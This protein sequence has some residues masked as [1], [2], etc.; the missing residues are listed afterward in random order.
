MQ[1]KGKGLRFNEGK[2]RLGL[3]PPFAMREI[4]RVFTYGANKYTVKN[5]DGSIKVRGDN[6]WKNG[7]PWSTVIDSMERHINSFKEGA[8][9]DSESGLYHLAHAATNAI[10][11]LEYYRIYPEGDDRWKP[12]H[13]KVGLDIDDVICEFIEP[14][15]EHYNI[16]PPSHWNFDPKITEN[17]AKL[18]DDFWLNL[19]VKI[20]PESIPFEPAVYIT[21]RPEELR[22]VTQDWLDNNGFPLA[23]LVCGKDKAAS[24]NE[25]ELDYFIDDSFRNFT[26]INSESEKT[27]C[28]LFDSNHNKRYDVGHL[29]ISDLKRFK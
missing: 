6:N 28:F 21:S 25:Y 19:P 4:A 13:P 3:L 10:F 18:D 9:F 27:A 20:S 7:M 2:P 14:Y 29:R 1:E 5:P 8:D 15:C 26:K 17:L 22:K 16:E 24:C 23:P 11:L 12:L